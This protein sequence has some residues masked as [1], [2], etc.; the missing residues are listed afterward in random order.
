MG[1]SGLSVYGPVCTGDAIASSVRLTSRLG[2]VASRFFKQGNCATLPP[3][4]P[5]TGGC[6]G[7][8]GQKKGPRLW[9][10][11]DS[12]V[13][14]GIIRAPTACC[15]GDG[16]LS[17][18]PNACAGTLEKIDRVGATQSSDGCEIQNKNVPASAG[19]GVGGKIGEGIVTLGADG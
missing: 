5:G 19:Q 11:N 8:G 4:D 9:N 12:R 6:C 16:I 10:G 15:V 7:K 13:V 2:N 3:P 18:D 17:S 14:V 1:D